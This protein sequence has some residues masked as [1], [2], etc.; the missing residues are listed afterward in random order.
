MGTANTSI[1]ASSRNRN[2]AG[3]ARQSLAH[4]GSK[5]ASPHRLLDPLPIPRLE[6][7]FDVALA[8]RLVTLTAATGYGKT[9]TLIKLRSF[10]ENRGVKTGWINLDADDS[11]PIRFLHHIAEALKRAVPESACA[12]LAHIGS[13]SAPSIESI[14]LAVCEALFKADGPVALFLDDYQLIENA[15]IHE[16]MD[17]LTARSPR[18]L[19]FFIASRKP[20]PLKLGKLRL[21]Q[22]IHEIGAEELSLLPDEAGQY[23]EA[24]SGRHLSA[25]HVRLLHRRTEGWVAGLQLAALALRKADDVDAFV[26]SLSGSNRDITT[27]LGEIVLSRLP[28][29]VAA[30]MKRTALFDRFSVELCRD[31]LNE[32]QAASLI[33][34][35]Q[36]NNLFLVPLDRHGQWYRYHQLFGD[37]LKKRFIAHAPLEAEAR[38]GAA[39]VWFEQRHSAHEAINYAFASQD[40]RRAADLVSRHA[41]GL[42]RRLG[43]HA[44]LASWINALP[45]ACVERYPKIR[46]AYIWSMLLTHRYAEADK[47]LSALEQVI[48]AN[49]CDAAAKQETS[50]LTS[51]V[52]KTKMM[53]CIYYGFAEKHELAGKLCRE[54]LT[55]WE[56][57]GEPLDVATVLLAL[58]CNAYFT[59]DYVQAEQILCKARKALDQ[60][61]SH[62][63][64][65]YAETFHAMTVLESGNAEAA[66]RILMAERRSISQKLG[67]HSDGDL[68]LTAIHAHA[69]YERN[70]IDAADRLLDGLSTFTNTYGLGEHAM[71]LALTKARLLASR[72][73]YDQADSYLAETSSAFEHAGMR[74]RALLLAAERIHL[75]LRNKR[76]GQAV[77]I[78]QSF[79][80]V[81]AECGASFR[82]DMLDNDIELRLTG[83]RLRLT[84]GNFG[85]AHPLLNALA[86]EARRI[87]AGRI[88]AKLLCIKASMFD[89]EGN[90]KEALRHIDDALAVGAAGGLCRTIVDEGEWVGELVQE[91]ADRRLRLRKESATGKQ[92][93]YLQRL[94]NA[95]GREYAEPQSNPILQASILVKQYLLSER[96]V[97]IL[98]LV[99]KGLKNCELAKQLFLSDETIKWHLRN[100]YSKLSVNNRSGAAARA[101]ELSLL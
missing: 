36:A 100:I 45:R 74:H 77:R 7:Q 54:W 88:L 69:H 51:L 52:S 42:V 94:L 56:Y 18:R 21:A 89:M 32:Q 11:D 72:N 34:T 8:K 19:A 16:A 98:K 57:D 91:I 64:T 87:G 68:L 39:S 25:A 35:I 17:W 73:L 101:R 6:V 71:L 95:F 60:C 14:L 5:L 50:M 3:A 81:E 31:V 78:A 96:E 61:C 84:S 86:A 59:R 63:G 1:D 9:T 37:Y 92:F 66:D 46:L 55:R 38:L 82:D 24:L 99:E 44:T 2:D 15:V 29:H 30:F 40:Y 90:R 27:Y 76:A 13:G 97:Q 65:A 62:Y 67:Q 22:D 28:E 4:F 70:D 26:Q 23:L 75:H 43:E 85:L 47:E 33:E 41:D 79:G 80:F 53:R 48:D 20:L 49:P 58:G 10:A 93:E 12:P 83:L